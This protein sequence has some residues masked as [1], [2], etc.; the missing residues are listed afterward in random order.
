M[1]TLSS[2]C[3]ILVFADS[4][5]FHG[6]TGQERPSDPRL[7]PNICAADLGPATAVDLVARPG[8]MARDGWWA[9]TKDPVVWGEYLP[10]ADA[11]VLSL[12]HMDQLPAAVPTWLRES[13]PFIR[14]GKLRRAVRRGYQ[15]FAPPVISLTGGRMVQLPPAAANHYLGRM[16]DAIRLLHPDLPVVRLLPAPWDSSYYPCDRPHAP[17]L[18]A[19]RN[20]CV[21]RNIPAVELD[22]LVRPGP[23]NPDGM[24]WGWHTHR[25]VGLALAGVLRE[26]MDVRKVGATR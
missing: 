23:N 24:H 5:A 7:F 19:G 25:R 16:V 11:V 21:E 8:Y 17:A 12:G 2:P 6:P 18:A 1:N 13:I 26:V 20:W 3:R 9:L 4:L 15:A 14:P 22:Q 10:R